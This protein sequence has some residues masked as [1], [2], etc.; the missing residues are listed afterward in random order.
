MVNATLRTNGDLFRLGTDTRV[1]YLIALPSKLRVV[2][3]AKLGLF[4]SFGV[5]F[6]C[7]YAVYAFASG[8]TWQFDDFANLRSLADA[9]SPAGIVNFVFGG[10]AGPLGRPLSLATFLANYGDWPSN[11]WGMVQLTMV[12]H[13]LNG[14][15]VF[16]L[17]NRVLQCHS[18]RQVAGLRY[19]WLALAAAMLWLWLPIHASSVLI[20]VQRMTHVSA[21]FALVALYGYVVL[22]QHQGGRVPSIGGMVLIS[23]WMAT[24]SFSAALG[25]ENGVTAITFAFLI[26][27]F[28]FYP[29]WKSESIERRRTLWCA[30]L[31]LAGVAVPGAIA[32]HVLTRLEGV[33]Q[34]FELYRGYSMAE[35]IA[36]QW[37][38]SLDYLR[39]IVIPRSAALGPFHDNHIVYTWTDSQPY[40]AMALWGVGL[41]GTLYVGK[42][43][44]CAP[45]V[46]TLGWVGCAAILWFFAGHQ[47]ESTLIPLELYFEHRNYLASL[48]FCLL[49]VLFFN[50]FINI[51]R[52]RVL[53][54]GVAL[55]YFCFLALSLAQ[56]TS[57]WG[58]PLLAHDLWQKN[59][60]RSIRA[61]QAEIQD[62]MVLGYHKAGFGLADEFINE[63][64][65]LDVAIS[66]M[67]ERCKNQ[68]EFDQAQGFKQIQD[69]VADIKTPIGISTGLATLGNTIRTGSC[70]HPDAV[71]YEALL[72]QLLTRPQ[73]ERAI[74]VR[75]HVYY[76]LALMAKHREDSDAYIG[77]LK[78]A[79]WDYP[80]ISLAQLVSTVLFREQRIDEAIA[81]IDEVI[82]NAPNAS[83]R[84]AWND[85]LQ[86]MR[87]ALVQIQQSL[88]EP[89]QQKRMQKLPLQ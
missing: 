26:E 50:Q 24:A 55:L 32:V 37:V 88:L 13:G 28:C 74:K 45:Q 80:T 4:A 56:L 71:E 43:K 67:P 17:L 21:F 85:I 47:L 52:S 89:D 8:L 34:A 82:K 73:V 41:W 11:P 79:F 81:W 29:T 44:S 31:A 23:A 9:N 46:R 60:P 51:S 84:G 69:L 77:Y 75:H 63:Y 39:Q 20:P 76:E 3:L 14:A 49:L 33:H 12:I 64:R 72:Q 61:V 5:G 10:V 54:W 40:A 87:D 78:K 22:R 65:A 86:S 83:L 1:A 15:L 57:L 70:A 42:S 59:N 2:A 27:L 66:V 30:W 36:T 18:L 19:Q 53:P 6:A 7:L 25:K 38:I 48:G 35:H 62:L 68:S 58:Q 16:L